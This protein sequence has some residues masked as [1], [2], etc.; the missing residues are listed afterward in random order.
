MGC[1]AER[2]GTVY[3]TSGITDEVITIDAASG[4][5]RENLR[6]DPRRHETDE[7]HGLAVSP[8]GRH[9][10]ATVSH[11]ESTLWKFE[12]E[13]DRLVG[14]VPLGI[15][16]GARIGIT[17]DGARAF[18]PDYD[19]G[20]SGA[21]SNVAVVELHDMIV[22]NRLPVCVGPHDAQV[23]PSGTDVA[24]TC[25]LSDEIVVL[26]TRTLAEKHRFFVSD[27]PGPAGAP[28]HKPLNVVWSSGG[29]LLYVALHMADVIGI[30]APDGTAAGR[31]PTGAAP[32]Q[33][34]ITDDG[35]TL[36][37]ANRG[38]GSV[39]I[40][41][42]GD[43]PT[44]T[45]VRLNVQHPHG[46]ALSDDDSTAFVSFEGSTTGHGGVVAVDLSSRTV[47][48]TTEAGAFNLGVVYRPAS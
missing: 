46:I 39:T 25:S 9:L 34:A 6:L 37:T 38:D 36:V 33:I 8:D 24:I 29:D 28:A 15:A 4:V 20:T 13:G 45:N 47:L 1:T 3:V 21:V 30:Y 26:D 14:R 17:P 10:Y 5:V 27:A 7:P 48:W 35:A 11:G 18:I 31:I 44:P 41:E 43:T 32:A 2:F 23:A 12:L 42:L 19:R 16:G 22:T 40:V